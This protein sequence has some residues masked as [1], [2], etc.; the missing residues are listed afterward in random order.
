VNTNNYKLY[1]SFTGY[2]LEVNIITS[3]NPKDQ[4]ISRNKL[5][6]HKNEL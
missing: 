1:L 5:F 3:I 2:I 6:L 4:L